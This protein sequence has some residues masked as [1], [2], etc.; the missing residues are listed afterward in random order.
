MPDLI[1]P[2]A[3]GRC[4]SA[5]IS[6]GLYLGPVMTVSTC[7]GVVTLSHRAVVGFASVDRISIARYAAAKKVHYRRGETRS[8]S[9]KQAGVL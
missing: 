7:H 5:H 9:G 1:Q 2:T 4:F 6:A 3:Q 8:H